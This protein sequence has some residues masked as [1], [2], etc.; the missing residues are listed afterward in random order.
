VSTVTTAELAHRTR[1]HGVRITERLALAFLRDWEAQGVAEEIAGRWRLTRS[2]RAMFSA[3][4][5]APLA[6]DEDE[7]A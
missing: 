7:A 5:H 2:G 1:R 4:V 6:H 3:W